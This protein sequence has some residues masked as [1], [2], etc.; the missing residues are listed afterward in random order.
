MIKIA[1]PT[2]SRDLTSLSAALCGDDR[3]AGAEDDPISFSAMGTGSAMAGSTNMGDCHRSGELAQLSSRQAAQASTSCA[4]GRSKFAQCARQSAALAGIILP[5]ACAAG[6]LYQAAEMLT[7]HSLEMLKR[8]TG[9]T[10]AR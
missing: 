1:L 4:G 7:H 6:S 2:L 9:L 3:S 10:K 8:R 5:I